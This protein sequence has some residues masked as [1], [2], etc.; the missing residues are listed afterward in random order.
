MWPD[1]SL[2][3][4]DLS[5][6]SALRVQK[7]ASYSSKCT[8]LTVCQVSSAWEDLLHYVPLGGA[9]RFSPFSQNSTPKKPCEL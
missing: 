6:T 9:A 3:I 8:A 5:V 2:M 4:F 7:E 1:G